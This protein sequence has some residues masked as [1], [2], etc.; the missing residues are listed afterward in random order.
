VVAEHGA[1]PVEHAGNRIADNVY[2]PIDE[3][4]VHHTSWHICNRDRVQLTEPRLKGSRSRRRLSEFGSPP[5]Y[6]PAWIDVKLVIQK[7]RHDTRTDIHNPT[8]RP[9][10]NASS[11][12]IKRPGAL[13]RLTVDSITIEWVR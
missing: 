8:V 3:I 2:V 1:A 9:N 10:L 12:D 7:G 4:A 13:L 11:A 5:T 6:P